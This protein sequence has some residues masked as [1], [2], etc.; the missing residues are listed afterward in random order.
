MINHKVIPFIFF[1]F[2]LIATCCS[3]PESDQPLLTAEL[4]LHLE[5]HLEAAMIEG[6]EVSKDVPAPVEWHFDEP[7]PGWKPII[8]FGTSMRPLRIKR[9]EDAL[10]LSLSEANKYGTYRGQ[11]YIDIP[12]WNREDWAYV[13]VRARTTDKVD[14]MWLAMNVR[15]K[16]GLG[17]WNQVRF[18]SDEVPMIR[19]GSVQTYLMRADWSWGTYAGEEKWEGPWQQLCL[20]FRSKVPA[21]IDIFS[22]SVIPKEAN[23]ANLRAGVSTEVR[24]EMY[25]RSLYTH[26]PSQLDYRIRV[27]EA[28]RLDIGLSVLRDDEPVTFKIKAKLDNGESEILLEEVYADKSHWA[29][30][31]VDLSHLENKTVNLTLEADGN[32]PGTVALWAAPTITGITSHQKPNIILYIIDGAAA[33]FMSLYGYN[34]RTTPHIERLAEEG[35]VF[36]YAYSNST[37][38]KPSDTSFMTS[39][40]HSVLGGYK[41]ESDPLPEQATT[42]AQHLHRA[43]YQT[44]VFTSNPYAGTI[45]NLDRG[46]DV[47]R[48]A[49]VVP[50]SRSSEELH[51]DFWRWHKDYPG[52]P[53]WAHF[54]TTDVH[55]PYSPVP[56]FAG[57]FI[58]SEGRK[59]FDEWSNKLEGLHVQAAGKE[60]VLESFESTGIDRSEF[61]RLARCMYDEGMAHNDYTI[62]RLVERL[63]ANGDWEHTIFIV[64]ADHSSYFS[65]LRMLDP[66]PAEWAPLLSSFNTRIPLIV[67]WPGYIAPGQRFSQPVSM[68]DILPTVLNLVDLSLPEVMQGQSLAPLLLGKKGWKP[69][70]VI[71]DEFY[72]DWSMNELAGHIEVI[73][74]CWGA[75]MF[76]DSRPGEKR[77][78]R[79]L[80]PPV[81]LLL[82]DYK[83][84]PYCLHSL[85]EEYPDLVKKYTEFLQAKWKEHRELAKRFTRPEQTNLTAEQLRTLRS[86]GYIK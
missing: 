54:Q 39:L 14:W 18:V 86:L 49:G 48:E 42:M 13:L 11:V 9:T 12:D 8:P 61:F 17:I 72:A 67:V 58:S 3:G 31:S 5:E 38:T 65:G 83:D 77:K 76:I 52:E 10:R 35:A 43:G 19:D 56:P 82:Y 84:D 55:F 46:V 66:L 70:P 41:A 74:G 79:P 78:S 27:P 7:Q 64:A 60:A 25:R 26:V 45:S 69:H 80:P 53:Y 20:G 73:D 32:R 37:W 59:V 1:I 40:H 33:E 4:P 21:T 57:L 34:R 51:K 6:S 81:P 44:A 63:K 36:E 22:V 75:S 47:L 29:Q 85:H 68:I 15:E 2:I 24:G 71:F 62:G 30:R 23:Y 16:P 28:G 50:N